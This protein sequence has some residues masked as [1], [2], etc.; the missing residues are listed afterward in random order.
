MPTNPPAGIPRVIPYLL[1]ENAAA[2]LDWLARAFGFEED[3]RLSGSDG[4]VMHAEMTL[5]D[6]RIMLGQPG[7][8]YKS[9]KQTGHR[10]VSVHVYVDDVDA[11]HE[12]ARQAGATI[13]A[14]P[15]D[16]TY[17]D[18]RYMAED[19]EGQQWVF[20]QHVRDV[21]REEWGAEQSV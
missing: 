19:L 10:P 1:Y 6:G 8:D 16:Q 9:P 12:R 15:A 20:A 17:G 2:A 3:L 7:G 5:A 18:R 21:S 11:H 14:E 4:H 13:T